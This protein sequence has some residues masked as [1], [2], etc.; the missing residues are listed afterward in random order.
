MALIPREQPKQ[1]ALVIGILALGGLY[2]LYAYWYT[3]R[4]VEVE[5]LQA[6]LTQL[7]D[8]NRQAQV[9]AAR[10]GADLE[11]RL[12]A[13]ERHVVRLEQLIP[14]GEEVPALLSSLTMEARVNGAELVLL[15]PGPSE[16]G[17]FYTRRTYDVAVVGEYH[18]VGSFLAAVG[19]LSRIVTPVDLEIEPV[20]GEVPWEE[21]ESP[22]TARFRI[23]T[24]VLPGTG[25]SAD[26]P[27]LPEGA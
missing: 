3:P 15:N 21:M 6:R 22:V 26:I 13:Y 8:R 25:A 10:G 27:T 17:E 24:Y 19:S 16:A 5:T 23:E 12:A 2:A 20:V 9:V 14:A 1:I 4:A 7:Q 11:E 18:D